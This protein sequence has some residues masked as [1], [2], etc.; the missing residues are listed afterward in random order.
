MCVSYSLFWWHSSW[1]VQWVAWCLGQRQEW[2]S[3]SSSRSTQV[4]T[5][6]GNRAWSSPSP[7]PTFR[8]WWLLLLQGASWHSPSRTCKVRGVQGAQWTVS[9][10]QKNSFVSQSKYCVLIFVLPYSHVL[11]WVCRSWWMFKRDTNIL[12]PLLHSHVKLLFLCIIY[13]Y[14]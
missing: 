12:N 13:D 4:D 10:R 3:P 6:V 8:A 9:F 14:S 5:W 7:P 2:T 11:F 1:P